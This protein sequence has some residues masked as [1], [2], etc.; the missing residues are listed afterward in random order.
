M[1]GHERDFEV[2]IHWDDESQ[3]WKIDKQ[4]LLAMQHQAY[5]LALKRLYKDKLGF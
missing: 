2:E 1:N 3:K 5:Y 4:K